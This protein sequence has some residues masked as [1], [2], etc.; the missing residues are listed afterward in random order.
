MLPRLVL[1]GAP[2]SAG[3]RHKGQEH[4]PG[5]LRAAGLLDRLREAGVECVDT[6]NLPLVA[7]APDVDHPKC[8]NLGLVAAVAARLAARVAGARHE[9]SRLLVLGGDCTLTLGCV[10]GLR[11]DVPD[12][13]LLYVD[14]DIDMNTPEDTP[15]GICD[16]MVL[17][18]MTGRVD[19]ALSRCGASFP[20]LPDERIVAFGC[21]TAAGY[22]DPGEWRRF[23]SSSIAGFTTTVILESATREAEKALALIERSSS[24]FLL[25]FDV[26]VVDGDEMPSADLPHPHGL[27]SSLVTEAL[28]VFWRSTR[29]EG[30]I[31][32]EYNAVRDSDGSSTRRLIEMLVEV[33]TAAV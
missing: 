27:P 22:I 20:L 3:A 15:S 13:G 19:N 31:V 7:F 2:S 29:C 24:R 14:G 23:E 28:K 16:G 10:A 8:Q 21:N 17:A 25:H 30:L 1:I 32:T 9:G 12:L 4:A 11:R 5:A 33:L 6:G 18:H 26:D